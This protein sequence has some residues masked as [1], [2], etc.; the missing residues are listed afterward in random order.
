M[1]L[2]PVLFAMDFGEKLR[3]AIERLKAGSVDQATVKE[4]IKELQRA[5]ISADVDVSLVLDLSK[6]LEARAFAEL[7]KGIN[8]R[9]HVVKATYD[10]LVGLLG[11]TAK[12]P[13]KPEKILL[14]GLF[15]QGKTTTAGKLAKWYAK[16]GRKVFLVCA[17]V[18]RPAAYD[19]LQQLSERIGVPFYGDK[20]EKRAE[21]IVEAG[22]KR[23]GKADLVIVD[24]AGRN[25]LDEELSKEIKR[26]HGVFRPEQTWLV[27]GGDLG[28]VAKKQAQAFHDGVGVNGVIL[29]RMDGSA[30]GGGALAACAL[31][32][33]P[34]YFLGMGE[35]LDDLEEFEAERYLSRVMGY[36][37]LKALLEKVKEIEFDE[38]NAKA[39]M[40]GEFNLQMFYDQLLATKSMGPLDKVM[41]MLGVKAQ[42]PKEA[43]DVSQKKLA[44]FK[45]IMDSMTKQEKR[46]PEL[47]SHARMERICRGAGRKV[48]EARELVAH[49]KKMK[50]MFK[51]F[52]K[53]GG[54]DLEQGNVQKLFAKMQAKKKNARGRKFRL[55]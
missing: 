41:E 23:A 20:D 37:D 27:L 7:P 15:G 22:L 16:R 2:C 9:E 50:K 10:L 25:G 55:R 34:V 42:L 39:M 21:K 24:S 48:E 40:E 32:Q 11:G 54:K 36:G 52:S 45:V 51:Q 33:S 53:L 17:D 3:Q 28:Q 47:M 8:R 31:T 1:F 4:V 44:S 38:E 12:A 5:L 35:K 14:V 30:K 19:Q 43:I 13:E 46:Q 26:V 29:T 49:Y 18:A 6:K